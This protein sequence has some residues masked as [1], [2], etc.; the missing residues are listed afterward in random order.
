MEH[1]KAALAKFTEG[2]QKILEGLK[3]LGYQTDVDEN[4]AGTAQRSARGLAE[5]VLDRR[6]VKEEIQRMLQKCFPARYSEM[7][8]SKHNVA[9]GVC[10]HHLLPVIYRISVA[11]IPT[12]KVLG[13][14]KLS[15]LCKLLSRAPMLQ[16]DLTHETARILHEELDSA[17][18]GVYVEGLHMCMASRGTVSHEARVVT[19][20][21]RGVFLDQ[22]A[23]RDEFINLVTAAHPTLI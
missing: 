20:A 4:F 11:Y 6:A 15:R 14:S 12:S 21:V 10:P 18:S 22:P 16:E 23:T 17:G 2:Y 1:S 9:F 13:I 7:V 19:S 5:L 8:I 3:D